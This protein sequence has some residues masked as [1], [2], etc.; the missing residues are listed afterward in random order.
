MTSGF[1]NT[2]E[3]NLTEDEACRMVYETAESEK[4]VEDYRKEKMKAVNG[5]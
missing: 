5:K 3:N 2:D 1:E 4:R